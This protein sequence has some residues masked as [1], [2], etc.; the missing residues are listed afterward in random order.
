MVYQVFSF[1]TRLSARLAFHSQAVEVIRNLSDFE[2]VSHIL[3]SRYLICIVDLNDL[4]IAM[5]VLTK[6]KIPRIRNENVYINY[7][8]IYIYE[9][10]NIIML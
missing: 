3:Y 1:V 4:D 8:Y 10:H 6:K 5:V 2:K 7:I 9:L